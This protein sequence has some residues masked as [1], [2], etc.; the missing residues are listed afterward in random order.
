MPDCVRP[1]R[2]S[3]NHPVLAMTAVTGFVESLIVWQLFLGQLSGVFAAA[4]HVLV[5]FAIAVQAV[6]ISKTRKDL[7]LSLILF[8]F[9]LA[10]GP[11][12]APAT[13]LTAIMVSAFSKE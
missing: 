8:S 1:F 13:F 4:G 2:L 7:R 11:A 10:T 6:L 12:G 3:Q 9:T 5:L